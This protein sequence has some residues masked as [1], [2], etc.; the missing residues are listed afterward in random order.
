MGRRM[1]IA[2]WTLPHMPV[3][4]MPGNVCSSIHQPRTLRPLPAI[5]SVK[6]LW[7][8]KG[9]RLQFSERQRENWARKGRKWGFCGLG[10]STVLLYGDFA[11]HV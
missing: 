10:S 7:T 1:A 5:L 3:E 11:L 4:F 9:G 6:K 8:T 2:W